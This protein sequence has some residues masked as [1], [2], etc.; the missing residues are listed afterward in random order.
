MSLCFLLAVIPDVAMGV[1]TYVTSLPKSMRVVVNSNLDGAIQADDV[2][3]LREAI[4]LVNGT[5][6]V[7]KLSLAEKAQVTSSNTPR[8]DFNLPI[9]KT[10]IAL[11][12]I[13]P[14]WQ[15]LSW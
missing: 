12:E 9:G 14:P 7:E 1:E 4:A 2:V 3:T 11:E 15:F 13:L 6:T 5:L 10:T 8:I